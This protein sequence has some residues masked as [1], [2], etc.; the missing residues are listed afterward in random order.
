MAIFSKKVEKIESDSAKATSDKE[1]KQE[2]TAD[3]KADSAEIISLNLPQVLVQPRI[4]EKAG[5][6]AKL[7]KYVFVVK[8]KANKVEVKKA[9]ES[10]YQVRVVQVNMV[11]TQGKTK[12]FGRTPERTAAFRKA[13]VTLKEGDA[14]KGL[15]DVA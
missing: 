8:K 6:L 2:K 15:T 12:S 5:Q 7:N 4:S 3:V 10:K 13:I 11:N 14:I 1:Q 9:V